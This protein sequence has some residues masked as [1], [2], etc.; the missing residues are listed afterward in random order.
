METLEAN[1]IDVLNNQKI[2]VN[3]TI[4]DKIIENLEKG[5]SMDYL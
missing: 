3:Q 5:S 4:T 1:K 2:D